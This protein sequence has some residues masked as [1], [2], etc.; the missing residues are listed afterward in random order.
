MLL[1]EIIVSD[2]SHSVDEA[3]TGDPRN[4][5]KGFFTFMDGVGVSVSLVVVLAV[6]LSPA[7]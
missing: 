6:S 3:G 7:N 4:R 5:T 2:T 1:G